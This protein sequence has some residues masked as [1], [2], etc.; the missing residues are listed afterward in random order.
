MDLNLEEIEKQKGSPFVERFEEFFNTEYKKKIE[1][2]VELFPEERSVVIDYKI[3]EKFDPPLADELLENPDSVIEAAKTAIQSIHIPTLTTD[4]FTPHIRI[5]NLPT[6][7]EIDVRNISS[8]HIG[9]LICIEGLVRQITFVQPKLMLA[10]W[11]CK[12]CGNV[13]KIIQE[14]QKTKYPGLCECHNKEF[15][16]EEDKSGFIDYQ[17]IQI[18]ETLEKLKGNDQ[19]T[20]I[21][22]Y[23]SEDLVNKVALGDKTMFTGVVRLIPPEKDKKTVFGRYLEVNY[24]EETEREFS[25]VKVT[26]EE[27]EAI[28]KLSTNPI[29]YEMLAKSIAPGIYG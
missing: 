1:R 3:L 6:D 9:K 13:Y 19:P 5:S 18:Q 27:E 7:R 17:K 22:V 21:E 11:K 24:L 12:K 29:I 2:V 20:N 26:K 28:K 10:Y 14:K 4:P 25:E 23:V 8:K 16:L 15:E